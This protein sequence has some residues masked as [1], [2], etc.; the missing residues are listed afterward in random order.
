M[1]A[2]GKLDLTASSQKLAE[3][4][5]SAE[6]RIGAGDVRPDTPDAYSFTPPEEFKDIPLDPEMAGAFRQRAHE[7]GLSAKQFEFVMGEYFR[8]VPSMLNGAASVS[9]EQARGELQKVWTQPTAYEAGLTNA[10]RARQA[11]PEALREQVRTKY[12]TDPLFFQVA[13]HFGAQLR[14][15][16]PPTPQGGQGGADNTVEA[17]MRSEAYN[18][19]KHVDHARVSEQVRK[20]YESRY[21]AAPAM[22]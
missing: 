6:K 14:E 11:L 16:R 21:G 17:L 18:N 10:E 5:A 2:D 13:A 12:G 9:A 7:A 8:L 19:P 22:N 4:Y 1:G 15:D 20:H 3:G